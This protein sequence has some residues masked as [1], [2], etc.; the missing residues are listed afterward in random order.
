MFVATR[1]NMGKEW[2]VLNQYEPITAHSDAASELPLM[3]IPKS[4]KDRDQT[5]LGV[6]KQN[7]TGNTI[8]E[9]G[10]D[11]SRTMMTHPYPGTVKVQ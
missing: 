6:I 9:Q 5:I 8:R 2:A 3:G 4:R 11:G 7:P 1:K 10:N